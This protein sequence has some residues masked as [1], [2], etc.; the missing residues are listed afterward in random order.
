MGFKLNVKLRD[1]KNVP[2]FVK[3]C[4]KFEDVDC[5]YHYG[6]FIIDCKSILGMHSIGD[7]NKSATVVIHTSN[8]N[9]IDK[10]INEMSEWIEEN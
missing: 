7:F 3:K 10:F 9:T 5:D 6:R 1:V 8:P 4:N 2:K